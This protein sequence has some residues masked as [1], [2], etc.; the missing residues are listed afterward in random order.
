MSLNVPQIAIAAFTCL[1]LSS[2]ETSEDR[3]LASAQDCIDSA[4]TASDA[5][6]CYGLVAGNESEKAYLVRCSANYIAQ[7]F[8]GER[9]ASAFQRLKDGGAGGQ[10]P[11]ATAMAYLVFSNSSSVHSVDKAMDNCT[12]SGVRSLQRLATMSKLATFITKT[13]LGGTIP[14]TA[15]PLDPA[16]NPATIQNAITN[17]V[18]SGTAADKENVGNIAI[19]LNQ[20]YCNVGSSFSGNEICLKLGDAITAGGGNAQTIGNQLLNLLQ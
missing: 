7:G 2:C 5:D 19:Q 18:G 17:L 9:M 14:A 1:I 6:R 4:R 12:R 15:N 10:D 16:F 11:M 3:Q 20:A 8:T 13:G